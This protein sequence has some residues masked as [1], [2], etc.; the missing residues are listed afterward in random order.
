MNIPALFILFMQ[1]QNIDGHYLC[2]RLAL[3]VKMSGKDLNI[4]FDYMAKKGFLINKRGVFY[5]K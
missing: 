1:K 5:V 2:F 3:G 4:R